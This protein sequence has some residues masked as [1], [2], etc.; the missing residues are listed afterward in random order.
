MKVL[1]ISKMTSTVNHVEIPVIDLK[2]AAKFYKAI[3]E[4]EIDLDTM[5]NYGLVEIKGAA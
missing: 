4:W 1:V 3:F 2:K 5:P